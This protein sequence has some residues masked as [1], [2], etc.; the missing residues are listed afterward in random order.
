VPAAEAALGA[1]R[2]GDAG[3][4]GRAGGLQQQAGRYARL[5]GQGYPGISNSKPKCS[6]PHGQTDGRGRA[7][8][9]TRAGIN[10]AKIGRPRTAGAR[11][12]ARTPSPARS[13]A[14][15]SAQTRAQSCCVRP[16]LCRMP[17]WSRIRQQRRSCEVHLST[18]CNPRPRPP[19]VSDTVSSLQAQPM[20][21]AWPP[22]R[23]W[24]P[25][26]S[27]VMSQEVWKRPHPAR[28]GGSHNLHQ[29]PELHTRPGSPLRSSVRAPV[30]GN[31]AELAAASKPTPLFR[32]ARRQ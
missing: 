2:V 22:Q 28:R 20:R 7:G 4:A 32:Q 12:S 18:T 9:C 14:A 24:G 1:L 19:A 21:Q 15:S 31:G 17:A 30:A 13:A 23:A 27:P 8:A 10:A 16:P 26:Q 5:R 3:A 11:A 29:P 25:G 6:M